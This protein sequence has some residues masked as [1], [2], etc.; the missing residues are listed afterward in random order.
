MS[1]WFG[2]LISDPV[3]VRAAPAIVHQEFPGKAFTS[4]KPLTH[5]HSKK[6]APKSFVRGRTPTSGLEAFAS[7]MDLSDLHIQFPKKEESL[8]M[9]SKHA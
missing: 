2:R 9:Y 5:R 1:A 4:V 6:G 7:T 8:G 3:Q